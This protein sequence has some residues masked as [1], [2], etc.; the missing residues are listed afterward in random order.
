MSKK[1]AASKPI[2]RRRKVMRAPKKKACHDSVTAS[3]LRTIRQI[4]ASIRN[5]DSKRTILDGAK[6][7]IRL[8]KAAGGPQQLTDLLKKAK[9][10]KLLP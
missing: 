6:E 2:K 9:K 7:L 3:E 8:M 10:L 4:S 1:T 5:T